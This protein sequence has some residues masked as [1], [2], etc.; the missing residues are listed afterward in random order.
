MTPFTAET[1]N[2]FV[3]GGGLFTIATA[4]MAHGCIDRLA[5]VNL[6]LPGVVMNGA[7]LYSFTTN[8]YTHH[9]PITEDDVRRVADLITT[10][11][12]GAF[13]YAITSAGTL[14][15]AYLRDEDLDHAQ[16]YSEAAQAHQIEFTRLSP[17]R[18][19]DLGTIIY[20]AVIGSDAQLDALE[21]PLAELG[22]VQTFLFRNIYTDRNCLEIASA[23]AGKASGAE[24]LRKALR[25]DAL[26]AFGD[27]HNDLGMMAAA[28]TSFAP[29]NAVPEAVA[30]ATTVIDTNDNDGVARVIM[31]RFSAVEAPQDRAAVASME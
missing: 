30:A 4:R 29:C 23:A 14:S 12:A 28:D 5:A 8:T 7:A 16:Y 13:A 21:K 6:T 1:I 11:S 10:N 31:E 19:A 9:Y 25:A 17:E 18:W 15:V 26:I 3:E 27:N 20:V 24:Y 2:R 22:T